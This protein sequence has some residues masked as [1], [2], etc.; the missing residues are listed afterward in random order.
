MK[1]EI[2]GTQLVFRIVTQRNHTKYEIISTRICTE[3][4]FQYTI[5]LNEEEKIV[6]GGEEQREKIFL[7]TP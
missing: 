6:A 1:Y 4:Q 5:L 3:D 7:Y 2:Q